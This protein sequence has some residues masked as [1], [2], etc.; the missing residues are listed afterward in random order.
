VH[1]GGDRLH[2]AASATDARSWIFRSFFKGRRSG[3]GK[4][5]RVEVG[6]G[7]PKDIG[8]AEVRDQAALLRKQ[9]RAGVGPLD[10]K[11]RKRQTFEQAARQL[12]AKAA[13]TWAKS[14]SKR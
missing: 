13:P 6:L 11:R 4:P 14:H 3:T 12:Y 7:S 1:A 9:C 10:E 8:L 2:L 5:Y